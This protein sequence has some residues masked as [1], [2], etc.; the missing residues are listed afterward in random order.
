M[1]ARRIRRSSGVL[2]VP[3]ALLTVAFGG[4]V[5]GDATPARAGEAAT[6]PRE[7]KIGW[8]IVA[9][10]VSIGAGCSVTAF[11]QIPAVPGAISYAVTIVDS[12]HGRPTT[13]PGRRSR[14]TRW[15]SGGQIVRAPAGKHRW[16]LSS[17]GENTRGPGC[18]AAK[19][20]F[21]NGKRWKVTKARRA[22]GREAGGGEGNGTI[23]GRVVETKCDDKACTNKGLAG[24]AVSAAGAGG[25][26]ATTAGDGRYSI[27]VESGLLPG[28]ALA[29]GS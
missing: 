1:T 28:D 5:A 13:S 23:A 10:D 14:G 2:V 9:E 11:L 22:G 4:L 25:G 7:V 20:G 3:F 24:V 12:A 15:Q 6:P 18:A 27:D 17:Y 19:A 26:R 29:Q 16:G 8:Q 21:L